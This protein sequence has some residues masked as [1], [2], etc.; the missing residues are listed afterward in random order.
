M[1][2][3]VL[4]KRPQPTNRSK[5]IITSKAAW[6]IKKNGK[7]KCVGQRMATETEHKCDA[8]EW[9]P[10]VEG[11]GGVGA[12][13]PANDTANIIATTKFTNSF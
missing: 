13:R 8:G 9:L 2:V 4:A 6:K 1:A 7:R 5:L 11:K 3:R 12:D 10:R